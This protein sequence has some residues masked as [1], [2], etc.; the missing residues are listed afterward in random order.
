MERVSGNIYIRQMGPLKAGQEVAGHSHNFDHTTFIRTGAVLISADLPDGRHI[1]R[2]FYSVRPG[3]IDKYYALI[4]AKVVH[5]IKSIEDDTVLDCIYSHRS[6][7][8]E[9]V[10]Q[11]DGWMEAYL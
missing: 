9:I 3:C 7:Q 4:K 11:Y 10:E 1:E 6:P 2:E 5:Q 8:G